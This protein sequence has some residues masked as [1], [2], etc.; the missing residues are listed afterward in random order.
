VLPW[1]SP[2]CACIID[3]L[4]L[5]T[6]QTARG[7]IL[8]FLLIQI[9]HASPDFEATISV[10]NPHTD[11]VK[12]LPES[13]LLPTFYTD[14]EKDLLVGTSLEAAIDQ[15]LRSLENEF[16]ELRE[17]TQNIPWCQE[18]W[19]DEDSGRLTFE[20]WMLVDALYRSRALDL[21]G[22][23][24]AMVP[25]MD[26]AN[27]ASGNDVTALYEI[28]EDGCAILQRRPGR[29][30]ANGEE[31]TIT[32]GDEKG[33]SE[34]IFSYGF[35]EPDLSCAKVIFLDLDIPDDDPLRLAKKAVN[36]EAPGVRLFVDE[37]GRPQWESNHIWWACVNEE[38]GLNFRVAQD[39]DG[40][41]QLEVLWKDQPIDPSSLS[42]ALKDDV[43]WDVFRL[44]AIVMLQERVNLQV[45][46]LELGAELFSERRGHSGVREVVWVLIGQLRDLEGSLLALFYRDFEEQVRNSLHIWSAFFTDW[47]AEDRPLVQRHREKL[48]RSC[49]SGG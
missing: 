13:V 26:M 37:D 17:F 3:G 27:H 47:L 20:D 29:E 34:M 30:L 23:G 24:H 22:A 6:L 32:Y 7:A 19:W 12:L 42:N 49:T 48:S 1:C 2:V 21:P 39:T 40:N 14:E 38:D 16:E 4:T 15:K 31:V 43:K 36:K 45:S 46:H 5:A 33:A 41:R 8:I 9:T 18:F 10:A 11:Y 44:R 25:C 28:D 35:L